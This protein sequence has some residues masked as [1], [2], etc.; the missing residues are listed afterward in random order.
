MRNPR[1]GST[2]VPALVVCVGLRRDAAATKQQ[3]LPVPDPRAGN[4]RGCL[5]QYYIT[6]SWASHPLF[7][8]NSRSHWRYLLHFGR[9]A[10]CTRWDQEDHYII[11]LT[12]DF[13][14]QTTEFFQLSFPMSMNSWGLFSST[15]RFILIIQILLNF[16][17]RTILKSFGTISIDLFKKIGI[18]ILKKTKGTY[19]PATLNCSY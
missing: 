14:T 10:C 4:W 11:R 6:T 18:E 8:I 12:P 3:Y 16:V 5:T 2:I 19:E 15:P 17:P 13:N 9:Y 1:G 7:S